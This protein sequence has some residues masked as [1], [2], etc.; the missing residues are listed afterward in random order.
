MFDWFDKGIVYSLFTS[1]I[2]Y[3]KAHS[4]SEHFTGRIVAIL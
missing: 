3:E 1:I 4:F 2:K